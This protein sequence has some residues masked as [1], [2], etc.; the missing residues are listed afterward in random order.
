MRRCI[1]ISAY[2]CIHKY[3]RLAS[4][5]CQLIQVRAQ[6]MSVSKEEEI[7][8]CVLETAG[9]CANLQSIWILGSRANGSA[10]SASDWD[11]LAF[12]NANALDCLRKNPDLHKPNVDFL[13]VTN[14]DNFQN[15]WGDREKKG[16]LSSWEWTQKSDMEAEYTEAKA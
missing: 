4:P 11:F 6:N 12:G 13:V 7:I 14:G 1:Y 5:K 8:N 3:M 9:K 2:R 10:H 16:S 15:A